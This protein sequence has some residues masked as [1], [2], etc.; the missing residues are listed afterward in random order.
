MRRDLTALRDPVGSDPR[1]RRLGVVGTMVW[2]TI[3]A[4]DPGREGPV[5]EWGG[6]AYAFSAFD[7]A[8]LG[9]WSLF[10]IVKVGHDLRPRADRFLR[11]L[12]RIE[13]LEGVRTVP[14][15]NNRVELHYRDDERRCE[16][17]RGGVPGWS[18]DELAPLAGCCDAVY[19]NFIAGWEMDLACARRLRAEH[20]GPLY[21]DIHSLL[22]GVGP[23]GIR[24]PRRP[25][26]WWEWLA[27][28]DLV[29]I[30]EDELATL[31]EGSGDPWLFA[32]EVVGPGTQAL[33]V[34]L[35]E[36]GAAWVATAQLWRGGLSGSD[37]AEC[38]E[39]GGELRVEREPVLSG[40]IEAER[41]VRAP[42]PT[43]CGDVWGIACFASLLG[44]L[45]LETSVR[46]ANRFA[47]RN[48]ELR[49]ASGIARALASE[50]GIVLGEGG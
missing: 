43:G 6:I 23:D 34:T 47:T 24:R 29:Q 33:F 25:E 27:C 48:A 42:D 45:D 17:L 2:D 38:Q 41:A 32:S 19:V 20:E 50:L 31:A 28:F 26:A 4:R 1:G 36:R 37:T 13:S 22:L 10:P 16:R 44:G 7:A 39:A 35:G 49:G 5:E 40:Q 8:A 30:N 21:G 46:R 14:E 18:W 11:S 15:P 12:V 3:Y 9:D